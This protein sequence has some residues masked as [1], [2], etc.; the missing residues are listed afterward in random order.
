MI[1]LLLAG[2]LAA[3]T[4][5]PT[6]S[7]T[8]TL[9]AKPTP[10]PAV[11]TLPGVSCVMSLDTAKCTAVN[12]LYA[13]QIAVDGTLIGSIAFNG[14]FELTFAAGSGAHKIYVEGFP[15]IAVTA[16]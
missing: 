4:A 11:E 1:A 14:P 13:R 6:P 15:P 5:L 2:I 7:A 10:T 9:D 12:L 8:P 16:P 3:A